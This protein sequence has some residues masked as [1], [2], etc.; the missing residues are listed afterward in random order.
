MANNTQNPIGS[1][2]TVLQR[3]RKYWQTQ[4]VQDNIHITLIDR[5]PVNDR[6]ALLSDIPQH[7][8]NQWLLVI[9]VTFHLIRWIFNVKN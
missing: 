6:I 9:Q 3:C 8:I 4:K 5:W 7:I 2:R 1:N